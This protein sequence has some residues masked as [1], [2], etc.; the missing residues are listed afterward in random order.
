[1]I[2]GWDKSY[3][4]HSN[5]QKS[6][7]SQA[8]PSMNINKVSLAG[9]SFMTHIPILIS[10]KACSPAPLTFLVSYVSVM[11]LMSRLISCHMVSEHSFF[12]FH[13]PLLYHRLS[14]CTSALEGQISMISSRNSSSPRCYIE[15]WW[16]GCL[17]PK[18]LTHFIPNLSTKFTYWGA[19]GRWSAGKCLWQQPA[20]PVSWRSVTTSVALS[21]AHLSI[22]LSSLPKDSSSLHQLG[23]I[24]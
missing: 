4:N 22:W 3:S 6:I 13:C 11:R 2:F 5:I 23:L 8:S 1:M 14:W 12:F 10:W 17:V 18:C 24:K 15:R 16:L 20:C 7:F 19:L 21:L 9:T